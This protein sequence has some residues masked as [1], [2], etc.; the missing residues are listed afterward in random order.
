MSA[1]WSLPRLWWLNVLL[2]LL[3]IGTTTIF[4]SALAGSFAAGRPFDQQDL[5][6]SFL[7]AYH[8]DPRL[9]NGLVFSIPLLLILLAH[10]L[11][12][13]ITCVKLGVDA[14]LPY[15]LP[16]PTLFGTLGAFIRI[17]TPIYTRGDLFDIG[18]GG[19]LAGFIMLLPFLFA[20]VWL[21]HP[22]TRAGGDAILIG[23]PL[24]LR[25]LEWLRFGVTGPS[26][27]LLHPMAMAA[28]AGMLVTAMNLLPLGQ[29]DGGHVVYAVFGE[30]R[31]RVISTCMVGVLVVMGKFYWPW[32]VWAV[33]MFFLGRRHPL[34]FD[35]HPPGVKR[36]W[37]ALA[38]FAIFILSVSFVP[39][40]L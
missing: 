12:H 18:S 14:T 2:L 31:H 11:G 17:K 30:R 32:W 5:I 9:V 4:G 19:P 1:R 22:L 35:D 38:A 28:L 15:F 40:R 33:V 25:A 21:S 23:A 16:S 37:L 24:G 8:H 26:H 13:Y 7:R 29:L 27:I 36:R 39:T 20:G 3:T 34:V 10:E 6:D